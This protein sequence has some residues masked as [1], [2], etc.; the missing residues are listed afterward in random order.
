MIKNER[1]YRISRAQ[2]EKFRQ[3]LAQIA[4]PAGRQ[5]IHPVLRRAQESAL[6]SQY[7]DLKTE[8]EEYEALRSGKLSELEL[9]SFEEF[10]RVLIQARIALGLSQK[11]LAERL[12]M[13]EQQIQ[14]YEANDYANATLKRVQRI[15]QA[16][17]IRVQEKVRLPHPA[18]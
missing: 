4:E 11:E 17:G 15:V 13:K 2:A 14:R 6:R 9:G 18:R 16:L 3:A 1:Q 12:G 10:P 7:E 5:D 8:V